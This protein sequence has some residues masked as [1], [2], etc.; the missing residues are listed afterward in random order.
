MYYAVIHRP[1]IDTSEIQA[2]RL[3]YGPTYKLIEPHVALVF[4][5]SESEVEIDVL[6]QHV[7]KMAKDQRSFA[8]H[9][10]ELELSWDQWLFLTPTKGKYD[11]DSLHDQLYD[12][13]LRPFLRA[14]IPYVPHIGLGQ[15]KAE[16]SD[17]SL[18]DPKAVPLN[19]ELYKRARAE[20]DKQ[21]LVYDCTVKTIE[22]V[23]I[24]D[25]FTHSE[26][27]ERFTLS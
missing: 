8:V 20:I 24:S 19:E 14:D 2:I 4:P 25:D 11:F 10:G 22:I 9:L 21:N 12:G 17:Y 5:L 13:L 3:K 16:D 7:A 23:S 1:E 6:K 26:T 15:F 18:K 27:V